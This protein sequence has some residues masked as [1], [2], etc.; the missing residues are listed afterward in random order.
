MVT[1]PAQAC[2]FWMASLLSIADLSPAAAPP[3]PA[4]SPRAP[5]VRPPW[6][7]HPVYLYV[8]WLHLALLLYAG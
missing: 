7:P 3:A 6:R 8:L 5:G 2:R 1:D 4:P